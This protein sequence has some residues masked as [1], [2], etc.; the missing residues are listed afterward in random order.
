MS[1]LSLILL[2]AAGGLLVGLAHLG[3]WLAPLAWLGFA[4]TAYALHAR[5]PRQHVGVMAAA[6]VLGGCVQHWSAHPWHLAT[7]GL[8]VPGGAWG[9]ALVTVPFTLVWVLVLRLPV[10]L[11]WWAARRF[12]LP[13]FLWLPPAWL[14]GEVAWDALTSLAHGD[15]L[16]TQWQVQPVLKAV[17]LLGWDLT[18]LLC[19]A[20]A[21]AVADAIAARSLKPI[22]VPAL[23][24]GVLLALPPLSSAGTERLHGVGAVHM[25]NFFHPP[26]VAP[27]STTLL[28]W[29]EVSTGR[30]PRLA[31]GVPKAKRYTPPLVSQEVYHLQGTVTRTTAGVQNAALT[32][33]PDGTVLGMRAKIRLFP[34]VEGP[35]LGLTFPNRDTFVPGTA[36]PTLAAGPRRIG[37]LLCL[38]GLDRRLAA[39]SKAEGAELLAISAS[40]RMLAGSPIAQEQVLAAAVM[41]AVEQRVPVVRASLYGQAA[42]IA[43]DGRVLALSRAGTDGVLTLSGDTPSR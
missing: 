7:M 29:P 16:Y 28:I 11:A 3:P 42:L 2:V 34:L 40:D 22:A 36:S 24:A 18:T 17:G 10:F 14:L 41:R 4:M 12:A 21:A 1:P 8:Y 30:R 35:F 31:E 27:P 38:E 25:A 39:R 26:K 15:W 5:A 13:T 6:L 23:V 33:G 9:V 37:S 32:Y 43:P 19:L 20:A